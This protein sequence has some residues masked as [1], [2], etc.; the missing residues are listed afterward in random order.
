MKEEA[1]SEGRREAIYIRKPKEVA[2]IY[3]RKGGAWALTLVLLFTAFVTMTVSVPTASA[4]PQTPSYF[5]WDGYLGNQTIYLTTD[6]PS[7]YMIKSP[8][9]IYRPVMSYYAKES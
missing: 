4:Q 5:G 1:E 2:G 8:I 6:I 3:R 7:A 9:F